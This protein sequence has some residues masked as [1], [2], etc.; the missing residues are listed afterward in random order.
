MSV[1]I[2]LLDGL[3]APLAQVE[4]DA[5]HV[6]AFFGLPNAELS[7]LLCDD[8]TIWP[9][10]RDFRGKDRPTDVLAFAQR[11]GMAFPG[12]DD[13][14][15]D[16][17]VSLET[18]ARQAAERGHSTEAELRI[19][20]VH[21]ICHLLGFDHER[22]EDAEVMEA[23]ERELLRELGAVVFAAPTETA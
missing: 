7:V 17:V 10:N 19:L 20:L 14:L 16:V 23:K 4:A 8:A 21:G 1:D 13:I 6:L 15:G 11:E 9:L 12:P 18:A 22:D 3:S 5:A 2:E